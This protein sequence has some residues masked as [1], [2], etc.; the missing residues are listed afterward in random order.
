ML[1]TAIARTIDATGPN[2]GTVAL[3]AG[4]GVVILDIGSVEFAT[5]VMWVK[6]NTS[7]L[8]PVHVDGSEVG[9]PIPFNVSVM[10]TGLP[11]D[12]ADVV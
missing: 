3:S 8:T 4:A 5:S 11:D 12:K 6:V 10:S 2:S 9:K 1:N 7:P